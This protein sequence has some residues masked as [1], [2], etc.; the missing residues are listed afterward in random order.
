MGIETTHITFKLE[1]LNTLTR[2]AGSE[3]KMLG[4]E[5]ESGVATGTLP[6]DTQNML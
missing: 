3:E 1:N 4:R 5:A 6:I 2:P